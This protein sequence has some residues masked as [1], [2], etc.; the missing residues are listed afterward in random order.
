MHFA[1]SEV[2][3]CK[4]R[5]EFGVKEAVDLCVEKHLCTVLNNSNAVVICILGDVAKTAFLKHQSMVAQKCP[6]PIIISLPHPNAR[7][8][9]KIKDAVM[10]TTQYKITDI[11]V[12]LKNAIEQIADLKIAE[13][14][15]E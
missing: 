3:H 2:V 6:T 12:V 15:F 7:K 4:S 1:I 5:S 13:T 14:A 8:P 11:P 10:I 9:R